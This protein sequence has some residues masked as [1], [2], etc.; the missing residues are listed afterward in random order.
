MAQ[1]RDL[2]AGNAI[3]GQHGRQ[4]QVHDVRFRGAEAAWRRD[5]GNVVLVAEQKEIARLHRRQETFD[6]GTRP[7]SWRG[8]PHRPDQPARWWR[9]SA[10]RWV[11]RAADA[12]AIGRRRFP[13]RP[14]REQNWRWSPS[15]SRRWRMMFSNNCRARSPFTGSLYKTA[16]AGV[17]MGRACRMG[18]RSLTIDMTASSSGLATANGVLLTVATRWPRGHKKN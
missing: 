10:R 7:E 14:S 13:L 18:P 3:A 17:R 12:A 5:D 1:T 9:R 11:W 2:P 4:H 16:T 8:R 6:D 15:R